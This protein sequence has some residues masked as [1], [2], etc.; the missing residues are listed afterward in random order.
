MGVEGQ[1]FQQFLKAEFIRPEM[2]IPGMP[3][4]GL[5]VVRRLADISATVP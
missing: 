5:R 4:V 1:R 3:E 2:T